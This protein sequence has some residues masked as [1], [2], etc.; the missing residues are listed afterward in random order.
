MP[1]LWPYWPVSRQAREAEQD[2]G[3]AEAEGEKEAAREVPG[4]A[5]EA[6]DELPG[7][8]ARIEG[9]GDHDGESIADEGA[10]D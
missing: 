1:L 10:V 2:E 7:G 8:I 6:A 5:E 3:D 9:R 4:Q